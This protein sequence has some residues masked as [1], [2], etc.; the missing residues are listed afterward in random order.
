[1]RKRSRVLFGHDYWK[2]I[3]KNSRDYLEPRRPSGRLFLCSGIGLRY[4]GARSIKVV[5]TATPN[6]GARRRVAIQG[7][8]RQCLANIIR[9]IGHWAMVPPPRS[10]FKRFCPKI[11]FKS[12]FIGSILHGIF[13]G[14]YKHQM[15]SFAKFLRQR[16][17]S[18]VQ[19]LGRQPKKIF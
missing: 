2:S 12:N 15:K 16:K 8:A 19:R 13:V 10:F 11:F 1:M 5:A 18:A 6:R 14:C 3:L 9:G 4:L 17:P 7:G